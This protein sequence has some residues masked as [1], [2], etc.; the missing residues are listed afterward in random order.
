MNALEEIT[1]SLREFTWWICI[2]SEGE[3][4][5]GK[6]YLNYGS[7]E[8]IVNKICAKLQIILTTTIRDL[9]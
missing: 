4:K 1:L 7:P 9:S 5:V 6:F 8:R 2:F 3:Y